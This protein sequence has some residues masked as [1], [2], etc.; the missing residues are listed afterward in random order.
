LIALAAAAA[1]CMPAAAAAAVECKP[2]AVVT[3]GLTQSVAVD[4]WRA[5]VTSL[6][7]AVWSNFAIAANKSFSET[8]L[9]V[10]ALHALSARPCRTSGTATVPRPSGTAAADP[11]SPT[12]TGRRVIP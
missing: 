3:V 5:R 4:T 11:P 10:A 8:N 2:T 6:H 1:A 9:G 12:P 7:G